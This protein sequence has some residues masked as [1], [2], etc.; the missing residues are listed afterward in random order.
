MPTSD[1]LL[2]SLAH[3]F[4]P[5][6]EM[7]EVARKKSSLQ[8]GIPKETSIQEKRIPLV[9]DAVALLVNN[10]HEVIIETGAGEGC[11]FS[12]K[13]YSEAGAQIVY[14]TEE[15]YKANMILKVE[16]PTLEE[17]D[18]MQHGQLLISAL[19]L[20]I[21]PKDFL[22][23]LISKKITAVAFDFIKDPDGILPIVTA[24]SEIA[25]NTAI[26]IAAEYLS[27]QRNGQGQM[28]GG[29]SGVSPTEVVILGAG[30]VG[31]F[32]ARTAVGLGASV[33]VFDNNIHKLR[34]L[35]TAVGQRLQT[36]IVQPKVLLK[37]LKSADV[38]IGA[39]SSK[40]GRAPIIVT[41]EMV[42]CMKDYSVI[43]DVSIDKGGCIET[44]EITSHQAPVFA[45]HGVIHYCVPNIA[46]RV[47]RTASY[48]LSNV[49]APTILDTGEFGGI[50][51]MIRSYIGIQNGVYIYKGILTNKYLAETFNMPYKDINLLLM[52][53]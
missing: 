22:K 33:K 41:E 39:I 52:A 50:D 11:S 48:A 9:P 31:E 13:D 18:L 26:L 3:G 51:A 32:A 38:V 36:S 45:K 34:R 20:P 16:P 42:K 5:Q 27:N 1:D 46:S 40:I 30:T 6:E 43:V 17:I 10:G 28:F 4:M 37:A 25:G 24:M 21:Q 47:A 2:K 14:G 8:I 49:I 7:L 53:M 19:Q 29:I 44:S 15:V 35:Q 23:K 12:D